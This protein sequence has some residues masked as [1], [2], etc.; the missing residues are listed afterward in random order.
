MLSASPPFKLSSSGAVVLALVCSILPTLDPSS[1][2]QTTPLLSPHP[3]PHPF[4][5]SS[6]QQEETKTD[7]SNVP[8][9][10]LPQNHSHSHLKTR[11]RPT[12]RKSE[13]SCFDPILSPQYDFPCHSHAFSDYQHNI[14]FFLTLL[15]VHVLRDISAI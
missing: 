5:R 12:T 15:S 11:Q 1:L 9:S 10:Q 3:H 6:I 13:K 14:P 4:V 8:T 7:Y 2:P